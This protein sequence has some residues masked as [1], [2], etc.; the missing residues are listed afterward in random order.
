[1]SERIVLFNNLRGRS[2]KD[3]YDCD[4]AFFDLNT[5]GRQSNQAKDL[6]KGQ[7]CVVLQ[8]PL[9]NGELRFDTYDLYEER[10][11]SDDDGSDAR[12][13]CGEKIDT[14]IMPQSEALS[15]E[16]YSALFD[17]KGRVKQTSVVI[18]N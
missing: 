9:S 3:V 4:T 8:E 14:E 2:H 10:I 13:F 6:A 1:M 16:T 18:V 15:H 5:T 11:F 7:T 17:V 12:V